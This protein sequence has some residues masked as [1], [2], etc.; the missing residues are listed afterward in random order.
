MNW[1]EEKF[2]IQQHIFLAVWP[3]MLDYSQLLMI[4]FITCKFIS[5]MVQRHLESEFT[6]KK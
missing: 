5:I 2:T 3:A 4:C 6:A 1:F